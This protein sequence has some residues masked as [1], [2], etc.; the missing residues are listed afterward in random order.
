MLDE[1]KSTPY[2]PRTALVASRDHM[3]IH[4]ELNKSKGMNLNIACNKA[5]RGGFN[6]IRCNFKDGVERWTEQE[7]KREGW[8]IQDIEELH[9]FGEKTG[10]C[11]YFLNKER[12]K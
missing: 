9:K 8:G 3:C 6:G 4:K 7:F 12:A 11:P 10:V 2:H 1:L 5:T